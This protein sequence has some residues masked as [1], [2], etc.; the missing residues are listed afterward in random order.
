MHRTEND[1]SY[2]SIVACVL[3]VAGTSVPSRCPATLG[4][5]VYRHR[6]TLKGFM[7]YAAEMGSGAMMHIPSFIKTG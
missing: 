5:Y 4:V 1:A 2:N 6:G 3:L 7:K